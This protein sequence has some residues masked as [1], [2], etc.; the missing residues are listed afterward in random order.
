M[1]DGRKTYKVR[2]FTIDDETL[3]I[4]MEHGSRKGLQLSSSLRVIVREW[5]EQNGHPAPTAPARESA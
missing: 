2:A 4:L 3:K 5:A 1:T